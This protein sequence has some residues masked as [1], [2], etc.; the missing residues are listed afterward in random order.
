M[1]FAANTDAAAVYVGHRLID[2]GSPFMFLVG[3]AVALVNTPLFMGKHRRWD[4][5]G[6][7][8]ET[9]RKL[10]EL[11]AGT[12]SASGATGHYLGSAVQNGIREAA[13]GSASTPAVFQLGALTYCLIARRPAISR[14]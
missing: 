13:I 12:P 4:Q 5:L 3:F 7:E 11:L 1:H 9:S 2:K 6:A 8:F 10:L 14:G